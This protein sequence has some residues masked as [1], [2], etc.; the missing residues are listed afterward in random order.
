MTLNTKGVIQLA[1]EGHFLEISED[2]IEDRSKAD[3]IAKTLACV[4]VLWM[5]IQC[6]GR[7]AG[8]L[9]ISLLELHTLLHVGCALCMYA[10]SFKVSTQSLMLWIP[11]EPSEKP[12]DVAQATIVDTTNFGNDIALMMFHP[13]KTPVSYLSARMRC[14]ITPSR[15][16]NPILL[17]TSI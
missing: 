11:T 12:L 1:H 10:L 16:P 2:A 4:Q 6:I 7:K 8:N 5:V 13:R 14:Q 3:G 17:P 15:S 9:P